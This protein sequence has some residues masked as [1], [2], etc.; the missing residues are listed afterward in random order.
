MATQRTGLQATNKV[1]LYAPWQQFSLLAKLL[2]VVLAKVQ[3]RGGR[4]HQ[5]QDIVCGLQLGHSNEPDLHTSSISKPTLWRDMPSCRAQQNVRRAY[6][7]QE[8]VRLTL[9]PCAMAAILSLTPL[10]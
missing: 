8:Q 6:G 3:L 1:P 2:G 9:L 5:S 4:L 7:G 10:S